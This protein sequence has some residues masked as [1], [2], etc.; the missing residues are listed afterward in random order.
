MTEVPE[1]HAL[2]RGFDTPALHVTAL[3]HDSNFLPS[4]VNA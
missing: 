1:H 2:R 4:S 3:F